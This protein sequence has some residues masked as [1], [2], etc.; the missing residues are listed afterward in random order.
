MIVFN[1]LWDTMK[2]KNI[3]TYVLREQYDI[4]SRT[5]RRLRANQ[6]VTTDTLNR[7][8]QILDCKLYEIAEYFPD[9]NK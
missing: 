4:D 7:L 3:S 6:N 8:C 1:K 2:S 5:I 9:K